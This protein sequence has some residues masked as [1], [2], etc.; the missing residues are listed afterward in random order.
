MYT[1][2]CRRVKAN[3]LK[4]RADALFAQGNWGKAIATYVDAIDACPRRDVDILKSLYSN[5]S[6]A[7]TKCSRY[8]EA[9]EHA[10][11]AIEVSGG[12]WSK[13]YWRR[14]Q[15]LLGMHQVEDAVDDFSKAWDLEKSKEC[16]AKLKAVIRSMPKEMLAW[17]M[18][19]VVGEVLGETHHTDV[20]EKVDEAVLHEASYILLKDIEKRDDGFLLGRSCYDAYFDWKTVSKPHTVEALIFRSRVYTCS[21]AYLQ[22]R[23]DAI[24]ALNILFSEIKEKEIDLVS[25]NMVT[26]AYKALGKGLLAEMD[27]PDSDAVGAL[28]AF[29]KALHCGSKDQEI[30]DA[31]QEVTE[32][33]TKESVEEAMNEVFREGNVVDAAKSRQVQ[34]S[35]KVNVSLNFPKAKPSSVN[36][37]IREKLRLL[38]SRVAGTKLQSVALEKV[39]Y[40]GSDKVCVMLE[41]DVPKASV[42]LK[43]M[44]ERLVSIWDDV[45]EN[46]CGEG[47]DIATLKSHLGM[48]DKGCVE[49]RCKETNDNVPIVHTPISGNETR[50]IEASIPKKDLILPYKDYKL[51][52]AFGNH[53]ARTEK[54]A[55]CMS[56]VYY[57]RSEIQKETWVELGD[58]SC[59]WRQSG[60]EIK[61]IVLNVPRKLSPK[62]IEVT[63]EPY[64]ISVENK[65]TGELYLAGRLH[66]GIIPDESFW[67]HVGGEGEDACCL[68]MTKMNLEVLKNHWKHSEMWWPKLFED[69]TEIAWDDYEKDY[70]DLPEEVLERH[71]IREAQ[72]DATKQ[73]ETKDEK[74]RKRLFEADDTRK[75][76]RML[77]LEKLRDGI[78]TM[79]T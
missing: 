26:A 49:I 25:K 42:D 31:I 73:I 70:S 60:S 16:S 48:L 21:K 6:L 18:M 33:L 27:H 24:S 79:S 68:T 1:G 72:R 54:H 59:R 38:L 41:V 62:L 63:F 14:A 15:A 2:L 9:K 50:I 3:H 13:G 45:E 7:C 66:R 36:P 39:S 55:F 12:A 52:D 58:G 23:E 35:T 69:H 17:K 61:V 37:Y 32:S 56:R 64:K 20:V 40:T 78:I 19:Q 75:K 71:K 4:K 11:K 74:R 30:Y 47:D 44:K 67:T 53:V 5:V 57:N 10:N 22:A 77:H 43:S 28:K 65:A 76:N 46:A 8:A 34:A 29:T 51:V